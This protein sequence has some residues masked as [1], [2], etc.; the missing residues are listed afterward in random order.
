MSSVPPGQPNNAPGAYGA[1]QARHTYLMS[2]Q[3]PE[4]VVNDTINITPEDTFVNGQLTREG[5]NNYFGYAQQDVANF[6]KNGNGV[7]EDQEI[8]DAFGGDTNTARVMMKAIDQDGQPGISV[9]DMTAYLMA[10]EAPK[11]LYR[12]A[13]QGLDDSFFDV[14][15]AGAK[16]NKPGMPEMARDGKSTAAE[17][18]AVDTLIAAGPNVAGLGMK[19]LQTQLDLQNRYQEFLMAQQQSGQWPPKSKL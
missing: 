6:D 11:Q 9:V 10:Q 13:C 16:A 17:R 18:N 14:F 15:E 2:Q 7:L 8:V 3:N 19:Q 1:A 5:L 12:N 4:Q